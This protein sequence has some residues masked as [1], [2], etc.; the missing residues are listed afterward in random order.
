MVDTDESHCAVRQ[1]VLF[2]VIFIIGVIFLLR[3]FAIQST[4]SPGRSLEFP[5][6]SR[7]IGIERENLNAVGLFLRL[8]GCR[9]PECARIWGDAIDG[10]IL[11]RLPDPEAFSI[12]E[13]LQFNG[14]RR[15]FAIPCPTEE[16]PC[17]KLH[18]LALGRRVSSYRSGAAMKLLES[19]VPPNSGKHTNRMLASIPENSGRLERKTPLL[20]IVG[21]TD[22][23]LPQAVGDVATD[24]KTIHVDP[25]LHL[26]ARRRP[27]V[28]ETP[29]FLVVNPLERSN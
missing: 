5:T 15:P 11:V 16:F 29:Y 9:K 22:S 19:I 23:D 8:Q 2:V 27:I 13:N 21:C 28:C 1:L 17:A 14:L 25:N 24:Q 20:N 4:Q 12:T 7:P 18:H 10:R 3:L 6:E 26:H